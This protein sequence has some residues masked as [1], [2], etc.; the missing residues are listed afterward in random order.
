[1]EVTSEE[2]GP[3][4]INIKGIHNIETWMTFFTLCLHYYA[5]HTTAKQPAKHQASMTLVFANH[6]EEDVIYPL[7]VKEIAEVLEAYPNIQ[8]LASDA[9]YTR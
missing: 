1:M 4:I 9:K 7:T 5:S 6:S 8:K 2:Y 3:E